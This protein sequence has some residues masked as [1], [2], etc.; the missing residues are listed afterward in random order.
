[1]KFLKDN[2]L[3][4]IL[5]N[6]ETLHTILKSTIPPITQ[7]EFQYYEEFRL[8]KTYED[9]VGNNYRYIPTPSEPEM[10]FHEFVFVLG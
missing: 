8:L 9:S 10:L 7:S 6:V 1:L 3:I 4:P 2:H 5:C